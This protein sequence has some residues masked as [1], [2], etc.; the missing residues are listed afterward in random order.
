MEPTKTVT[1]GEEEDPKPLTNTELELICSGL[2]IPNQAAA[3][4]MARELRRWRGDRD[5]DSP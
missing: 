5:P 3:K 1:L 4:S 2:Q